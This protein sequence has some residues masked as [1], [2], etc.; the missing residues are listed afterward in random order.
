MGVAQALVSSGNLSQIHDRELRMR[1]A[2]WSGLLIENKRKQLQAVDY[3]LISLLPVLSDAAADDEWT[4]EERRRIQIALDTMV[5][6]ILNVVH[7]QRELLLEAQG[8]HWYLNSA[9]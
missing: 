2:R 6:S 7:S 1:L 9:P 3:Q 5:A 4:A 8:I